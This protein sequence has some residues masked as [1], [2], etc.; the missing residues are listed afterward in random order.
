MSEANRGGGGAYCK[1]GF[2]PT[3]KLKSGKL[4]E[5]PAEVQNKLAVMY[6]MGD[7]KQVKVGKE[8]FNV[9]DV[10]DLNYK[11]NSMIEKMKAMGKNTSWY[12]R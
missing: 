8:V 5:V 6:A 4:I 12:K 7:M 1:G 10:E 3:I 9:S 11:P 2:M